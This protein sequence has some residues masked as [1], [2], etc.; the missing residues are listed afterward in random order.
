M[1]SLLCL[2]LLS[3]GM[4]VVS[5]VLGIQEEYH[6]YG[7]D[8]V[9]RDGASNL[10]VTHSAADAIVGECVTSTRRVLFE[11]HRTVGSSF[12]GTSSWRGLCSTSSELIRRCCSDG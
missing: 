6:I 3:L 11:V 4:V 2:G 10:N 8:D 1:V 9:L 12:R 7:L 5:S